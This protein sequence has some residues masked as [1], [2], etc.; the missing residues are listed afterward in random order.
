MVAKPGAT[1]A[2]ACHNTIEGIADSTCTTFLARTTA[3]GYRC[4]TSEG[5]ELELSTECRVYPGEVLRKGKTTTKKWKVKES[6]TSSEDTETGETPRGP[7]TKFLQCFDKRDREIF[8]PFAHPGEFFAIWNPE[9]KD[10][11][12]RSDVVY[13]AENLVGFTFPMHVK[14]VFGWPP[15]GVPAFSGYLRIFGLTRPDTLVLRSL[16]P[17][18]N[19][20][21]EL[22]LD[23]NA[24]IRRNKD[25]EGT[26]KNKQFQKVLEQTCDYVYP[27]LISMKPMTVKYQ[28]LKEIQGEGGD[29]T[30][31]KDKAASYSRMGLPRDMTAF[32]P[33]DVFPQ[34]D[35][36][37]EV[38]ESWT[39][40]FKDPAYLTDS[41]G[42]I[43]DENA[44]WLDLGSGG[45]LQ[46]VRVRE[47]RMGSE[48]GAKAV[49]EDMRLVSI[50][51]EDEN[52][53]STSLLKEPASDRRAFQERDAM[54]REAEC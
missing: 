47:G 32:N 9:S 6:E 50:N 5:G 53:N 10:T 4:K 29:S 22:P 18:G 28:P 52:K 31:D 48:S 19:V 45:Q 51:E 24:T 20:I 25:S 13:Y 26:N 3:I 14:V 34:V 23:V 11:S 49:T 44:L 2:N 15:E 27:Y 42:M 41:R 7:V 38:S 1:E 21:V 54:N 36:V 12:P 33:L 35:R 17:S 39:L 16:R 37:T 40:S 8:L 46:S 43:R 30:K